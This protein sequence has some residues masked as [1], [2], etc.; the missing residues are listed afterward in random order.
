M[1]P[2]VQK[3][4]VQ[5]LKV[6]PTQALQRPQVKTRVRT[7]ID[8][9]PVA[10]LRPNTISV[11]LLGR[12]GLYSVNYDYSIGGYV[13]LGVGFS[14]WSVSTD[15]ISNTSGGLSVTAPATSDSITIVP[16]YTNIYLS[17]DSHR[18][19]LSLGVDIVSMSSSS[20]S[21]STFTTVSGNGVGP[22]VGAGYEYRG[23]GGFLFRLAPYLFIGN[24]TTQVF[25][26][27][28]LGSAF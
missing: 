28:S 3:T 13:S 7:R 10:S 11:E 18:P 4:P 9:E 24:K 6:Q 1:A 20:G 15:A 16:I 23:T 14:Y 2:Q 21:N 5:N 25:A 8:A 12:G 27:L 22:V 19:Y 17:P 26:G